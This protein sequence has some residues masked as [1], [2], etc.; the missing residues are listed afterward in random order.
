MPL[1]AHNYY[2]CL[3]CWHTADICFVLLAW[4]CQQVMSTFLTSTAGLPG[5]LYPPPHDTYK[6]LLCVSER[7]EI[8]VKFGSYSSWTST[9]EFGLKVT[10]FLGKLLSRNISS[11]NVWIREAVARTARTLQLLYWAKICLFRH[12]LRWLN[13][14]IVTAW[15]D[16]KMILH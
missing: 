9:K 4:G 11:A 3:R 5:F 6:A 8:I 2:S 12:A 1:H 14:S 15:S 7:L 13:S 16:R 10:A